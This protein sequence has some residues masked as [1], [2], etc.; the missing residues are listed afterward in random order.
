MKFDLHRHSRS[1]ALPA[2]MMFIIITAS[3][4]AS[5]SPYSGVAYEQA[6]SLKVE[7]LDVMSLA[8]ESYANHQAEVENLK[9]ELN[10][11]FEFAKGRPKNEISAKQWE[12][13]IDSNRNLLGGFLARWEQEGTLS[14]TFVDDAKGLVS[15]AFDTIIGLES[16]KIKSEDL[17][18]K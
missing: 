11:A 15:D 18:N 14:Q 2:V 5:I 16:G 9:T 7:S 17:N 3:S 8:T 1:F 4:C 12:I 10:K 6:T 13:L